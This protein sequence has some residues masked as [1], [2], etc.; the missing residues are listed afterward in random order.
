MEAFFAKLQVGNLI[1]GKV[2]RQVTFGAFVQLQEGI[3][4][5]CHISEMPQ[6]RGKAKMLEVGSE[7]DFRI[8]RL[9]AIDKKIA[10]STREPEPVAPPE[11]EVPRAKEPERMSTMAEA[12]SSAGITFNR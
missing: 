11:P 5:L 1:H 2:T 9:N 7:R 8:I 12:L 6:E 10:L 3:E 4:G